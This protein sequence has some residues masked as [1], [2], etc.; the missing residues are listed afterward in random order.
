MAV[1][2]LDPAR[3][4]LLFFDTSKFFVNG[5]SLKAE[6]RSPV[7]AAA[8]KNW[9]RLLSTARE[10]GMMVA[11]ASTENRPDGADYFGRLTDTDIR[12]DPF[13]EPGT[14]ISIGRHIAGTP[15]VGVIDEIAPRPEDY[16]F[17]KPRW[18][19]FH[20]TTFATCLRLRGADT[21]VVTGG[22]TEI[23]VAATVY[24]AQALD[25][26]L[27]VVSDACTSRHSD[28]HE[29]LMKSVFPR[30]S[31]VRTTDQVVTM[32]RAPSM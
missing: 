7:A 30:I 3:T 25:F 8:V 5:P 12:G 1:D 20:E 13:P 11:Y 18:S 2:N 26:D 6:D 17:A 21:I 22:S 10:L 23:G 32:L 29:V 31:R 15:D 16:F 27:V 28:C 9:Q 14:R 4:C 24:A 19:A